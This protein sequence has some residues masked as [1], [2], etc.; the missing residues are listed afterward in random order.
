MRVLSAPSRPRPDQPVSLPT[1]WCPGHLF[2]P[3]TPVRDGLIKYAGVRPARE[4]LKPGEEEG[5]EGTLGPL[6]L[7][8]GPPGP[9]CGVATAALL[10]GAQLWGSARH[11]S[12]VPTHTAQE[13]P[14]ALRLTAKGLSC[15]GQRG[16]RKGF[17]CWLPDHQPPD[18]AGLD[19]QR[20]AEPFSSKPSSARPRRPP[21]STYPDT[22]SWVSLIM[23]L[24]GDALP[25][26]V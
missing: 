16:L 17:V 24:P 6:S 4:A 1:Y 10:G 21:D 25:S 19:L 13:A 5:W 18:P 20:G 12:L 11:R 22:S 14:K 15:R 9:W 8:P 26:L 3:K 2:E 23:P 7:R